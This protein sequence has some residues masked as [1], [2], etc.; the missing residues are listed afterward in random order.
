MTFAPIIPW[1]IEM[2]MKPLRPNLKTV[3]KEFLPLLNTHF[4]AYAAGFKNAKNAFL[5]EIIRPKSMLLTV[6]LNQFPDGP[7]TLVKR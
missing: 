6:N 1:T 2:E 7:K 3:R 4:E 5:Q